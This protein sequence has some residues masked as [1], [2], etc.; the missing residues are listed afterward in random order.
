MKIITTVKELFREDG[1]LLSRTTTTEEE[2]ENSLLP[3][4]ISY[5]KPYPEMFP[6]I[7]GGFNA[8]Y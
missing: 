7:V 2:R 4:A 6:A 1:T 8:N 3:P 5:P